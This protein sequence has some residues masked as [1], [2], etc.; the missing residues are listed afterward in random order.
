MKRVHQYFVLFLFLAGAGQIIQ[1]QPDDPALIRTFKGHSDRVMSVAFSPDGRYA[2][3]GSNDCTLKLWEVA[4]GRLIRTFE[5]WTEATIKG[6]RGIVDAV[7]FSPDGRYALSGSNDKTLKLWEV[8]T[9]RLIRTFEGHKGNVRSV[10]FSPDGRNALSGSWDETLKLWDVATGRLIRTIESEYFEKVGWYKE[11]VG[12]SWDV[13]SVA[14]SPGGHYAL[15]GSLGLKLWEVSTGKEIRTFGRYA[16][17]C[18]G[19]KIWEGSTGEGHRGEV[20]SVAFSPDGR[21]ALSGSGDKTLKLWEVS[22]GS[23]IQTFEGHSKWV[24][25]VAFSP[26]GRYALSG[27]GDSTLKLW[28]VATGRLIQTF[29]GG[30][31]PSSS[32]S[33]VAFSPDGRNALSGSNYETKLWD[34]SPWTKPAEVPHEFD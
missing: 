15:S 20:F 30:A 32:V 12:H 8:A 31:G 28:E 3:S 16:L 22:T 26:D 23:L 14:F 1:A 29:V 27:S 7:A 10:A 2:L 5:G 17:G 6:H 9:G 21:Y 24:S 19:L 33:S 34:V 11:L 4:T 18:L 13:Y 25:S